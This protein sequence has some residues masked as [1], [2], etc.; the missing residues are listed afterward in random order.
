MHNKIGTV[1]EA[2]VGFTL[3]EI[4]VV[5][6]LVS[7]LAAIVAIAINPGRQFSQGRD[8][9]RSSDINAILN[10]IGQ[11]LA[12]GKGTPCATIP[13]TAA[14]IKGPAGSG[15]VDLKCLVPTYISKMPIDPKTGA[16]TNDAEYDTK[17][18]I[19]RDELTGRLTVTAPDTEVASPDLTLTR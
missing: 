6:G 13:T 3:I 9:Q 12:D 14:L 17:Y 19:V 1:R 16:W 15:E 2:Q 5:I 4:L 11:S 10:A 18:S 8:A 7:V